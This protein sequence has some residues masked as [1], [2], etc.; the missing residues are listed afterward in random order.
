[1]TRFALGWCLLFTLLLI[2]GTRESSAFNTVMTILH[3]VLVAFIIIAG[4]VKAKPVNATPFFPFGV[5][6]RPRR[7]F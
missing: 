7:L 4:F 5:R 6:K 1:M 2:L 3:I